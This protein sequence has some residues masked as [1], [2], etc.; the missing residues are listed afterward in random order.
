M[1]DVLTLLKVLGAFLLVGAIG[2][3][4]SGEWIPAALDAIA[5]EPPKPSFAVNLGLV[6]AA[7][8][9]AAVF[10]AIAP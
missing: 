5:P 10:W 8:A 4:R 3:F 2:F 6:A 1:D 9:L 7:V